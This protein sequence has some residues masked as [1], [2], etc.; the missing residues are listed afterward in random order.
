M[1]TALR[2]GWGMWARLALWSALLALSTAAYGLLV[3]PLLR[4]LFGG[5]D[6]SWPAPIATFLPPAPTVAQLRAILPPL[7]VG[8]AALKGLA[9][10]RH[11]VLSAQL[12]QGV[13][14]RVRA[15]AMGTLLALTPEAAHHLGQGGALT[16]LSEDADALERF[17]MEGRVALIRDAAQL[18]ALLIV[19]V[20]VEWRLALVVFGLY[21]LIFWPVAHLNRRLRRAAGATHEAKAQLNAEALEAWQ[22]RTAAQL[23]GTEPWWRARVER[24]SEALERTRLRVVSTRALSGPLNEAVGALALAATLLV[25]VR[26]IEAGRLAAEHVLSFF[27]S[28]LLL[29]QP[30]KGVLRALAVRAPALAALD[31]LAALQRLPQLEVTAGGE[32]PPEG[33]LALRVRGLDLDRAGRP[34]VRGLSFELPAGESLALLGPNG[35]GKS[36]V[37]LA[38]AGLLAPASGQIFVN[39]RPLEDL[40]AAAW[41][42]KVGWVLQH[43]G[44]GRGSLE[45]NVR[46]GRAIDAQAWQRG[47]AGLAA[48]V[49]QREAGWEHRLEGDGQSLSGGEMRRVALARA[50]VVRPGLLVLDEPEAHLD[51]GARA[52]LAALIEASRGVC[53]VL[54]CTHD[55]RLAALT[56]RQVHLPPSEAARGGG[57]A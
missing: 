19:C 42:A 2:I 38:L 3:G 4:A 34:V 10:Y 15:R 20:L 16:H 36:S 7:L 44:V 31:R 30:A 56:A 41:R 9:T 33:A 23:T 12:G 50:L 43:A 47:T 1:K 21:P 40:D 46:W 14:R 57:D 55:P 6:L 52:E 54:L 27:V 5:A 35:A 32:A 8:A 28:V 22:L 51:A 39:G 37:V 45:E 13:V 25:A 11:A 49:Q 53:T 29:Y 26:E 48:L 24:A 18:A 17:V